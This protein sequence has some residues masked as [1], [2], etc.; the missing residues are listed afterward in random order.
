MVVHNINSIAMV[1]PAMS[2]PSQYTYLATIV[3]PIEF[4]K[5]LTMSLLLPA[6]GSNHGNNHRPFAEWK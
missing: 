2:I 3:T 5:L 1:L 6:S 4:H